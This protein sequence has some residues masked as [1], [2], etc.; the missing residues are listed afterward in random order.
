[1][2]NLTRSSLGEAMQLATHTMLM[3]LLPAVKEHTMPCL[4]R[5]A[6]QQPVLT[7]QCHHCRV[8]QRACHHSYPTQLR[9]PSGTIQ[10]WAQLTRL[11]CSLIA[12]R[13][14]L[15]SD[16]LDTL[17]ML[18]Q[19]MLRQDSMGDSNQGLHLGEVI[20]VAG[21]VLCLRICCSPQ[22]SGHRLAHTSAPQKQPKCNCA[23]NMPQRA[24]HLHAGQRRWQKQTGQEHRG[25]RELHS[26]CRYSVGERGRV[27]QS[28]LW[29]S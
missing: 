16:V 15:H 9:S 20:W 23:P 21:A 18:L 12:S 13:L 4:K 11:R 3:V 14:R 29:C 6:C 10:L 17:Q 28:H 1:M 26:S 19:H 5:P 27:L 2:L 24:M 8:L 25:C 22:I 7:R